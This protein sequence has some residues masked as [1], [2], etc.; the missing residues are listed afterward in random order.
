[1]S[2][3]GCVPRPPHSRVWSVGQLRSSGLT[4]ARLAGLVASGRLSHVRR[5]YYASPDADPECVLAVRVGG[6]L[7]GSSALRRNGCWVPPDGRLHVSLRAN[8]ARLRIPEGR[9]V[10]SHWTAVMPSHALGGIAG[11]DV[12]TLP[13]LLALRDYLSD[14]SLPHAVAAMDSLLHERIASPIDLRDAVAGL[15][16]R[17]HS[18]LDLCDARAES[19]IESIARVG[20]RA[21]GLAVEPQVVVGR[22][23]LDLLVEGRLAVELDGRETH[24][25]PDAFER[26]R[27]RDTAVLLAGIPTLRFSFA[28]VMHEWGSVRAAVL[29][30]L[31]R[32]ALDTYSHTWL[33][34][35]MSN[36]PTRGSG[37]G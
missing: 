19:E 7:T 18:L 17:V 2:D 1:M 27:R 8:A 28:Q 23:R 14:A 34:N 32:P 15:P 37:R 4:K 5:G 25:G 36:E 22:A 11:D 6:R 12:G 9:T 33:V 35:Y 24:G 26:D 30:A 29:A 20:L 31:G 21:A 3:R 16:D 13:P 10:V